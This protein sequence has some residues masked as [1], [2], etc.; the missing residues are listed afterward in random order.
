MTK[1][2]DSLMIENATFLEVEKL[3]KNLYIT[4]IRGRIRIEHEMLYRSVSDLFD[5]GNGQ[6]RLSVNVML[7]QCIVTLLI[8]ML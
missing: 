6:N 1:S 2:W 5:S 7:K 3:W 8:V 4:G